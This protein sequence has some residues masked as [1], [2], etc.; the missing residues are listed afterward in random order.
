[1]PRN[2][3][4]PST[5]ALP[6]SAPL[7]APKRRSAPRGRPA[8]RAPDET[9]ERILNAAEELFAD[10]GFHGTSMR[11]VARAVTLQTAAVSYHYP[12]KDELFDS[13][14]RR[15]ATVMTE[16]RERAL[17]RLRHAHGAKP[18]PLDQLVHAYVQPFVE[19][20]SHGDPGWRHY[21]ALMGR[22]AN[23][24][25]GTEV[26]ARHYDTTAQTY[27]REFMRS[28]PGVTEAAVVDG[29]TFMV[30]SM[31]ALCADTGRP[32]RLMRDRATKQRPSSAAFDHLVGFLVSGFLALPASAAARPGRAAARA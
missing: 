1:M 26:I 18:V 31:L 6:D 7:P 13:V 29:F 10:N 15:R 5:T 19:S 22:L 3:P 20:A 9:R 25:L 8:G 27:L 23:S 30:A 4:K 14:I 2:A 21:A 24:T 32:Q 17:E 12:S 28:L 16:H 11:D